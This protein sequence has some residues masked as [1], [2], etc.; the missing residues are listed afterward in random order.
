MFLDVLR[1]DIDV[2]GDRDLAERVSVALKRH[3]IEPRTGPV[4]ISVTGE[5]IQLEV[6]GIL[7]TAFE[8]ALRRFR[9]MADVAIGI[10]RSLEQ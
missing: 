6:R 5:Q 7:M 9:R 4:K 10:T 1:A 2:A 3:H 8:T